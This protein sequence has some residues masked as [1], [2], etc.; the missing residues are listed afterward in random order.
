MITDPTEPELDLSWLEEMSATGEEEEMGA[1]NLKAPDSSTQIEALLTLQVETRAAISTQLEELDQ[2]LAILA[3][4]IA[5]LKGSAK[6][7]VQ[8]TS[9]EWLELQANVTFQTQAVQE[10]SALPQNCEDKFNYLLASATAFLLCQ[11]SPRAS[12]MKPASQSAVLPL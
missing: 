9:R 4:E 7:L 12:T 8:K 6:Q 2:K 5:A 1:A 11:F 3:N 10:F